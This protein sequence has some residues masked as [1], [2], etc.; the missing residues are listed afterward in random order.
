MLGFKLGFGNWSLVSSGPW[1]LSSAFSA[2]LKIQNTLNSQMT[3]LIDDFWW[4]LE[5]YLVTEIWA[6]FIFFFYVHKNVRKHSNVLFEMIL[7][8]NIFDLIDFLPFF[9]VPDTSWRWL[10]VHRRAHHRMK[11][12]ATLTGFA[13][14]LFE[15]RTTFQKLFFD[16]HAIFSAVVMA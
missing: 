1:C 10:S 2:Y 13:Q 5:G 16:C 6:T 12:S 9:G 11:Y 14:V 4:T 15:S 8:G 3:P 7:Y